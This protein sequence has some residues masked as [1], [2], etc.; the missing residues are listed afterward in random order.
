MVEQIVKIKEM[1][2]EIEGRLTGREWTEEEIE[3]LKKWYPIEGLGVMNRLEN[4]TKDAIR[5]KAQQLKLKSYNSNSWTETEI[6]ILRKYYPKEGTKVKDRLHG[7]TEKAV[8][9]FAL[10][11]K[12][13]KK[14]KNKYVYKDGNLSLIHI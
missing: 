13:R 9:S 1:F 6:K 8:L 7:R 4:R 5:H 2:R 14:K 3:I 12:L 11:L 10:K